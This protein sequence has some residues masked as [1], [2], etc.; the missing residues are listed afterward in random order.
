MAKLDA[1]LK[2]KIWDVYGARFKEGLGFNL[3]ELNNITLFA[4]FVRGNEDGFQFGLLIEADPDA[5][6]F[7]SEP[8]STFA[9]GEVGFSRWSWSLSRA[10]ECHFL[11][12]EPGLY[13][14][15]AQIDKD[16]SAF[17]DSFVAD[18]LTHSQ[19][20][21]RE[22]MDE[23]VPSADW[24]ADLVVL[25]NAFELPVNVFDQMTRSFVNTLRQF[26]IS[27]TRGNRN[28]FEAWQGV[29]GSFSYSSDGARFGVTIRGED[30]AG[31][32]SMMDLLQVFKEAFEGEVDEEVFEELDE[33][34][35]SGDLSLTRSQLL[36][37]EER[38]KAFKRMR[39]RLS[40]RLI[41]LDVHLGMK[42]LGGLQALFY[43]DIFRSPSFRWP[44]T[45]TPYAPFPSVPEES[46][47]EISSR[48]GMKWVNNAPK[49]LASSSVAFAKAR[50]LAAKGAKHLADARTAD[51][52]GKSEEARAHR[53]DAKA[54]YDAA[55]TDTAAWEMEI[56]AAYTDKDRQVREIQRERTKWMDRIIALHKT[57][58][59]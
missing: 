20:G 33:I 49:G 7:D 6:P 41:E 15:S 24:G 14:A 52:A 30:E 43:Q 21:W 19:V 37:I 9:H 51:A 18:V 8:T 44:S 28:V 23:M 3:S 55:F 39:P 38:W 22:P 13:F 10:E 42:T 25:M 40:D 32:V 45:R 54:A 31:A 5:L 12:L 1:A 11:A 29:V 4:K 50:E 48:P 16:Q 59:R 53:K 35:E 36:H 34:R 47:P 56:L 57:T 17:Y 26:G 2:E 27:L 58:G 46:P